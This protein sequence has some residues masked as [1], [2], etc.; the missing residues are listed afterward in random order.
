MSFCQYKVFLLIVKFN[1][2]CNRYELI[3]RQCLSLIFES[4]DINQLQ[5]SE[6]LEALIAPAFL[7]RTGFQHQI[8]LALN[9]VI[10]S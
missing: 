3:T 5:I 1:I 4:A 7:P 8:L 6:Q 9:E 2:K 10:F